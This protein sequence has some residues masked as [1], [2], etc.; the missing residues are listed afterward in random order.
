MLNSFCLGKLVSDIPV[1]FV[2]FLGGKS[3]LA[4]AAPKGK[5]KGKITAVIG[6]V[7]DVQFEDQLPPILN[8]L[9][10]A[11]RQPKLIL[12]VAQHLGENV[13]R[14][15][16]MDGTEG[17]VRGQNVADLGSPITIPVGPETLG[18]I[19]NVIGTIFL[20]LNLELFVVDYSM[21]HMIIFLLC[22][23]R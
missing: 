3:G 23:Y 13:V 15:I 18:R 5:G 11:G 14:T 19:M 16:A 9:E 17:L 1:L 8:A 22:R 2:L 12:E 21:F 20:L 4:S 10:V 7:V 6:A